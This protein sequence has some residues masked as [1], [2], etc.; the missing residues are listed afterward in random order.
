VSLDP[1]DVATAW[2]LRT[3]AGTGDGLTFRRRRVVFSYYQIGS[4]I[5]KGLI[6]HKTLIVLKVALIGKSV[7]VLILLVLC[8]SCVRLRFDMFKRIEF[9]WISVF[10]MP[11]IMSALER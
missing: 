7:F 9:Q 3:S 11:V 10:E 5:E 4:N 2:T 6:A 1:T 8:F